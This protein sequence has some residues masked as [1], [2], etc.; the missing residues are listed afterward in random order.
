[1]RSLMRT[2]AVLSA[3]LALAGAQPA[4]LEYIERRLASF[5]DRITVWNDQ[6][7]RYATEYR[8]FKNRIISMVEN[9]D[10]QREE[11]RRLLEISNSRIERLERELDYMETRNPIP[12]CIEMD[13]KLIEQQFTRGQDKKP[14]QVKAIDCVH[15]IGSIRAMKIVKKL[16]TPAGLWTRDVLSDSDKLYVFDGTGNDTVYEFANMRDFTDFP[17]MVRA[18]KLR[19]PHPWAGTGHT[20]F[21]GFLYYIRTQPDFQVIKYHLANRTVVDSAMF[22]AEQQ[23]PVYGLSPFTYIDLAAD[24]DGLWALYA[25]QENADHICLARMDLQTLDIEQMWDTPCPI[26][27][28]EGAFVICG[29]VYVVYNSKL[30]SRSRIQCVFDVSD[31]VT[32]ENAP[33]LYFPRRYGTHSSIKYNSGDRHLYAWDDGYQIIYRLSMKDK[34]EL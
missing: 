23:I 14:K 20:V 6:T 31:L 10:K 16:D 30:R 9:I 27:D 17:G 11:Q 33:L 29:T 1:M 13:D 22:P 4:F 26:Q 3:L 34:S 28:A 18:T 5:E 8:D 19:L 7:Q 24:E 12:T 25:T 2:L 21:Q 15:A 32:S